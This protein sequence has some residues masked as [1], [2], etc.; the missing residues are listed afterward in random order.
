MYVTVRSK[1]ENTESFSTGAQK[2]VATNNIT[3]ILVSVWSA[4]YLCQILSKFEISEQIFR[5]KSPIS[6]VAKPGSPTDACGQ[7]ADHDEPN[8]PFSEYVKTPETVLP[9]VGLYRV[10]CWEIPLRF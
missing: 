3:R 6:K 4:R 1:V 7:M 5:K 8:K 2:C 10:P 9:Y